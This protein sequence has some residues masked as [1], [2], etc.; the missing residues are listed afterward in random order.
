MRAGGDAGD[1]AVRT[2]RRN[3]RHAGGQAVA[4]HSRGVG[5]GAEIEQIDEVGV[6]PEVRVGLER[7]GL[8]LGAGIEARHRRN[9]HHV[10]RAPGRLARAPQRR[11]PVSGFEGRDGVEIAGA[12]DDLPRHRKQGVGARF[13]QRLGRGVALG[14]PGSLVEQPRH[15]EERLD[16]EL[17]YLGAESRQAL[18]IGREGALRFDVAEEDTLTASRRAD[19]KTRRRGEPWPRVRF[20]IGVRRVVT[21]PRSR[22][23]R[24]GVADGQRKDRGSCPA[25][26]TRERR[27]WSTARRDW[28]SVRRSR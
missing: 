21:T 9:R 3:Q 22:Q 4:A 8:D 1:Q 18:E 14:D 11:K 12:L 28:A 19:A 27:R 25:C 5:E 23:R 2:C 26:G 16:V 6:G 13:D 10:E 17:H 24:E 15:L 20:R 7:I